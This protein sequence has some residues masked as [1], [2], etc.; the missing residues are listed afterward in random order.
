MARKKL[1]SALK[2]DADK[3]YA[4]KFYNL[5]SSPYIKIMEQLNKLKLFY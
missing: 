5:G 1:D 4:S 2:L 3:L